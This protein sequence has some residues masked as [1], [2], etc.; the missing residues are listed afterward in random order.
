MVLAD[1]YYGHA[2]VNWN[3]RTEKLII[4]EVN[5]ISNA[6]PNAYAPSAKVHFCDV[7]MDGAGA[8]KQ[9]LPFASATTL[10]LDTEYSD[11]ANGFDVPSHFYTCPVTGIYFCQGLIRPNDNAITVAGGVNIGL[12]I[13]SSNDVAESSF[14]WNKVP[15]TNVGAGR[16]AIDYQRI[17]A[18]N[19]GAQLRLYAFYDSSTGSGSLNITVARMQI[20]R[21]G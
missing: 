12:G 6:L 8:T 21:V 1:P 19:A 5:G 3:T 9:T 11:A 4:D 2:P 17:G 16:V 10:N 14:V 7:G 20:W 18:F 15:A 13:H